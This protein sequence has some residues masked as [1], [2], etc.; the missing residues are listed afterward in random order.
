MRTLYILRTCMPR[1]STNGSDSNSGVAI[2]ARETPVPHAG[3]PWLRHLRLTVGYLVHF[4]PFDDWHIS[5][6]LSVVAEVYPAFVKSI[7]VSGPEP[8]KRSQLEH[9]PPEERATPSNMAFSAC[10]SE[11]WQQSDNVAFE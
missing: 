4:W 8:T 9:P 3:L 11:V 10:V 5:G 6:G 7:Y 2:L 1:A